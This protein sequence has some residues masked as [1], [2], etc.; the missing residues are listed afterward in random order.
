[1][2]PTRHSPENGEWDGVVRRLTAIRQTQ[3]PVADVVP[4]AELKA[5]VAVDTNGLEPC[6]FVKANTA[7]V[8]QNNLREGRPKTLPS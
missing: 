4:A 3:S 5:T 8:R 6:P 2:D 7:G 1:M